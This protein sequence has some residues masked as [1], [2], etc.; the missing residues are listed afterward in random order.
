MTVHH[1]TT[2]PTGTITPSRYRGGARRC[3]VCVKDK[4]G[5]RRDTSAAV[6]CVTCATGTISAGRAKYGYKRCKACCQRTPGNWVVRVVKPVEKGRGDH[7]R[8]FSP[9]QPKQTQTDSWWTRCK[10]GAELNQEA[11]RRHPSGEKSV[12]V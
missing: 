7:W 12:W 9:R 6:R 3:K 2:C 8:N 5:H 4:P 1:C 10:T 11:V